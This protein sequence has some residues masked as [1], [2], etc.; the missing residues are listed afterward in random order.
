M[1]NTRLEVCWNIACAV[2]QAV[3]KWLHGMA[4]TAF[5]PTFY[6]VGAESKYVECVN[7]VLCLAF[8]RVPHIDLPYHV[9]LL[10]NCS[11]PNNVHVMD[12]CN[13]TVWPSVYTATS[14]CILMC[15]N[16]VSFILV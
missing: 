16:Q 5:I 11:I 9:L 13:G 7:A 6:S 14:C 10:R 1:L 3:F 2:V 8:P 4:V 15:D 12:L